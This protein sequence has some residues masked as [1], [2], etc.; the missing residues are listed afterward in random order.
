MVSEGSIY[1]S[2]RTSFLKSENPFTFMAKVKYNGKH[3]EE[4]W[5]F[6]FLPLGFRKGNASGAACICLSPKDRQITKPFHDVDVT[7]KSLQ[8]LISFHT[9]S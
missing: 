4:T 3:D 6:S 7:Y 2:F 5:Q 8:E 1:K 9:G